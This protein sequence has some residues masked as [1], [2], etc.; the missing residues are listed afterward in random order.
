MGN[1]I[2]ILYL[3]QVEDIAKHKINKVV[4][5]LP[6]IQID[7]VVFTSEM[8]FKIS[9]ELAKEY[10]SKTLK[11]I[12]NLNIDTVENSNESLQPRFPFKI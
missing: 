11:L 12:K 6:N 2:K 9:E 3:V 4:P 5:T 10:P 1:R 7:L 8:Y